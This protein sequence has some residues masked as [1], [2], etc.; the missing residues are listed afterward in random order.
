MRNK[1]AHYCGAV[2]NR[3]TPAYSPPRL[4]R[5]T[6][7]LG[8]SAVGVVGF[9]VDAAVLTVLST[10]F[11]FNVYLARCVSFSTAVVVT[12]FLNRTYVFGEAVVSERGKFA[13]YGRYLGIQIV[14]AMINLAVFA[15]LLVAYPR[16]EAVPIV[17]LAAGSLVALVFNFAGAGWLVFTRVK[18]RK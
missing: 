5:L 15:A 13:E 4:G 11:G 12:W 1:V 17:P 7:F 16:L 9:V 14:G 8:F 3:F 2:V 10:G 18:T 6:R